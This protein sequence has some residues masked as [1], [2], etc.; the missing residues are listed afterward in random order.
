MADHVW[1]VK[2]VVG[3]LARRSRVRHTLHSQPLGER[4]VVVPAGA[5]ASALQ[6]TSALMDGSEPAFRSRL[7]LANLSDG[8]IDLPQSH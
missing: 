3:F 6:N 7:K 2:E 4:F 8:E 1:S 5:P